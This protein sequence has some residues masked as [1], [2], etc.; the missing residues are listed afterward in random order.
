MNT[1][2]FPRKESIFACLDAL[3]EPQAASELPTSEIAGPAKV[4]AAVATGS[5]SV[6]SAGVWAHEMHDD[7][8]FLMYGDVQAGMLFISPEFP[9]TH[10]RKIVA[11]LNE[12]YRRDAASSTERQP[13]PNHR[14]GHTDK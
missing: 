14:I 12:G 3:A 13:T 1:T 7:E 11:L 2:P 10:V 9:I 8:I 4:V 6:S 5:E